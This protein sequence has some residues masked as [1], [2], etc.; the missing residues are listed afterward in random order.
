M[1]D[2]AAALVDHQR[3][4]FSP[5]ATVTTFTQIERRA[6]SPDDIDVIVG[7]SER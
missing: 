4:A 3:P 1:P 7:H 2:D 5:T 6:F